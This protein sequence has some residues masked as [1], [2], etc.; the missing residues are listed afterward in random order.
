MPDNPQAASLITLH[1]TLRIPEDLEKPDPNKTT[2][3]DVIGAAVGDLNGPTV[4]RVFVGPKALHIL[5]SVHTNTAPGQLNGPD[6]SR[7][8]DFGKYL[9]FIAKPLFLWLRWTH[10]HIVANW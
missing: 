3:V 5:Q 7:V 9:G 10:D 6:L 1:S 8:V 4:E 2:P